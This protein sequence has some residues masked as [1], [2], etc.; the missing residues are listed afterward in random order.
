MHVHVHGTC[1]L[2]TTLLIIVTQYKLVVKCYFKIAN[3]EQEAIIKPS[4]REKLYTLN[5]NKIC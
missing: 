3:K 2:K 1:F 5:E 4:T